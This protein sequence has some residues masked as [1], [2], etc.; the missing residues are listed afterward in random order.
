MDGVYVIQDI[1]LPSAGRIKELQQLLD[2]SKSDFDGKYGITVDGETSWNLHD[3]LHVCYNLFTS[4]DRIKPED[5]KR[6][7]LF[8]AN[9][10]PN[11]GNDLLRNRIH[12]RVRDCEGGGQLLYLYHLGR[13]FNVSRYYGPLIIV[14]EELL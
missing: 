5:Y 12:Q 3:A 14:E 9:D 11:A 6:M 8:T 2:F 4:L 7:W 13:E 10:N 1:G